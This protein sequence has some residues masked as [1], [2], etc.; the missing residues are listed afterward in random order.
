M[1]GFLLLRHPFHLAFTGQGPNS[2]YSFEELPLGPH[3]S[4]LFFACGYAL[5]TL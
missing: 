5:L 4:G 2:P 3:I 1:K